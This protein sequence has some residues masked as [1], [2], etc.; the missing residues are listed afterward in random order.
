M[1]SIYQSTWQAI[2]QY[3]YIHYLRSRILYSNCQVQHTAYDIRGSLV[4]QAKEWTTF[5]LVICL[6][7][8]LIIYVSY[9]RTLVKSVGPLTA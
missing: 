9:I 1:A 3:L 7:Q 6:Q 8:K 5:V 2:P 4:V